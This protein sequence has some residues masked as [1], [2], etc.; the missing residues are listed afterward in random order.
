M[1]LQSKPIYTYFF[2][3]QLGQASAV[4]VAYIF[5][6]FGSQRCLVVAY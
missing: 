3:K 5:R 4:K 1:N 6:D 2:Y